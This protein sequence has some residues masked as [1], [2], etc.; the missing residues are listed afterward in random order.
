MRL[1]IVSHVVHYRCDGRIYAYEPYVRE[2]DL[3]AGMFNEVVIASPCRNES[4][5]ED[6][7]PF[8]QI[9]IK[10][11]PQFETGGESIASKALQVCLV[12]VHVINLARAMLKANAVHVRCP[13]NLGLLGLVLAPM[14]TR[15]IVAK[16]AGQWNPFPN[17]PLTWRVQK[18][19]LRSRWWR[20]PVTVYGAWPNQP[21]NIVPFFTSIMTER[22]LA[23]AKA[24]AK[25]KQISKPTKVL[26]VGRL[27]ASKNVGAI[28]SAAAA[29]RAEG[30]VIEVTIVGDGPER[31]VLEKQVAALDLGKVVR[32][33]GAV[34]F[35]RVLEFYEKCDVLALVSKTEAWGKTLVEGMSFGLVCIGVNAGAVPTIL[36]QGRGI[37]IESIDT[38]GLINA[39]RQV[40][41]RPESFDSMRVAAA[42]WA[43]QYSLESLS[44]ALRTLLEHRWKIKLTS[45]IT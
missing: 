20:G 39:F 3:W 27:T 22:Q 9:N 17:E 33:E 5:P 37:L 14:F 41:N 1:V 21:S 32:F 35:E 30:I 19:L 24:C 6:C 45:S 25:T 12:P 29:L 28:I 10:M 31:T 34:E 36:G 11:A 26:Y 40:A 4:P 18:R 7:A 38:E 23:R 2:I 43:Q 42:S 15:F 8:E 16:Y 44:H 13:G